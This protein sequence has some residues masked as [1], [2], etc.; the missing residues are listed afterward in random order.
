MNNEVAELIETKCVKINPD[1]YAFSLF[2]FKQLW[3]FLCFHSLRMTLAVGTF[4]FKQ[5]E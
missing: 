3:R 5:E 2:S 4:Y 1:D